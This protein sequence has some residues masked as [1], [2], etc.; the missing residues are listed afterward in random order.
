MD[1]I[2]IAGVDVSNWKNVKG[3]I[4]KAASNPKYC[5]SWSF[6]QPEKVV[7]L[8]LWYDDLKTPQGRIIQKLDLRK[9]AR[10][11]AGLGKPEW[12]R[13]AIQMDQAI[14]TALRKK[15]P[16]RVVICDGKMHRLTKERKAS[17][18]QKRM[19][20]AE[21]WTVTRYDWKTGKCKVTRGLSNVTADIEAE[22]LPF[23]PEEIYDVDLVEGGRQRIVVNSYERNPRARSI[24][25][26]HW[27]TRCAVCGFNFEDKY[28]ES[29][30]GLVH[31]HHLTPVSTR[32]QRYS[33]NP[34][35]H[36]RPVCPNCHAA[37]HH[38]K[39]PPYTIDEMKEILRGGAAQDSKCAQDRNN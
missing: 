18:V 24:C 5:Y 12:Q 29:F 27:G 9:D 34:T 14:Q 8:N 36:L 21:T 17:Q 3:G 6:V 32:D 4:K 1:L 11:Y 38:R 37:L 33:F 15:L 31:V 22:S 25:L 2:E 10:Q 7:V 39:N 20:D 35:R 13:R 23:I 19:L 28:G 16:V 26:S 30:R